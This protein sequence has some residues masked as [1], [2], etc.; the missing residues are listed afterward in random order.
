MFK[1][2]DNGEPWTDVDGLRSQPDLRLESVTDRSD[3]NSLT[4]LHLKNS[5][6]ALKLFFLKGL[7]T[8][9]ID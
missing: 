8:P 4:D 3:L 7:Q 6:L 1:K 2:V 9:L 5:K